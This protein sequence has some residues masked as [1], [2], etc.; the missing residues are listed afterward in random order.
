MSQLLLDLKMEQPPTLDNFVSGANAE[1]IS[2]LRGLT[3]RGSFDAVY[4]WGASGCG[5]SHLLAATIAAA[6]RPS[7]LL[8]GEATGTE[9]AIAPACCWLLTTYKE[10]G[11]AAQVA[12]F[13]TFNAARLAGLAILL[14]GHEPPARL[15]LREDLRTRIGQTLVYEV[16]PLSD[17]EK[18]AALKRH[19]LLR[20]MKVDEGLVRYLLSRGRRDLNSLMGVLDS[21][22]RATLELKRPA[23]LP[24]LKEVMQL[25]FDTDDESRSV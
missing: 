18:S 15:K 11:E 1:L 20:G 6:R 14:A 2:R 7:L 23:T 8:A 16:K 21:L 9:I 24:L 19:A 22:D 13:R 12:L 10:L 4:L 17:D 5:K 3:D 25:Q